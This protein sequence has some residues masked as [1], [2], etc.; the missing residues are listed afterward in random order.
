MV[1]TQKLRDKSRSVNVCRANLVYNIVGRHRKQQTCLWSFE[2]GKRVVESETSR[3]EDVDNKG[4]DECHSVDHRAASAPATMTTN[5]LNQ[6]H[7]PMFLVYAR[8][9]VYV[10]VPKGLYLCCRDLSLWCPIVS[11]HRSERYCIMAMQVLALFCS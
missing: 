4:N 9:C 5:A 10:C 11:C 3:M 8:L 2:R 1:Q 6:R 7:E